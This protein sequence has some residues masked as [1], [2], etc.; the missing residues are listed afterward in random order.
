VNSHLVQPT[1]KLPRFDVGPRRRN[2]RRLSATAG[3]IF[4]AAGCV[5]AIEPNAPHFTA[6][7]RFA[8]VSSTDDIS[9]GDI[10]A[11]AVAALDVGIVASATRPEPAPPPETKPARRMSYSMLPDV[12]ISKE[13]ERKLAKVASVYHRRTGKPLVITSGT[14]DPS[15]QARAM[16]QLLSL[17]TDVVGL[18]KNKSAA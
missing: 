13:V 15:A 5:T 16:Y 8:P 6:G 7:E 4:L 12:E 10:T 9:F 18:Y 3:M 11:A 14:R 2:I 1:L 17:G